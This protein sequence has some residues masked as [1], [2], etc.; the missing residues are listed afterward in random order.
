MKPG[1]TGLWQV[2]KR[3]DIVDYKERVELDDWYVLNVSLKTDLYIIAKT[4]ACM[5][6]GKGAY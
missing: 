3:S 4:I 5:F 6:N 1:I 2:M